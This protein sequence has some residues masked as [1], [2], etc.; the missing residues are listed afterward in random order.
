MSEQNQ[1]GKR[2]RCE[3]CETEIICVK[4]GG[5]R[6]ECHGAPIA[7]LPAKPLPSTD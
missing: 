7:L 4:G 2:Y 3:V 6:L 5:G 1:V